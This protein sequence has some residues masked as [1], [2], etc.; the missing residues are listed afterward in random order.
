MIM[1][2]HFRRLFSKNLPIALFCVCLVFL[3]GCRWAYSL[4]A[5]DPRYAHLRICAEKG[6]LNPDSAMKLKKQME[7][8][9]FLEMQQKKHQKGE[10]VSSEETQVSSETTVV[11]SEKTD[12]I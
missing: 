11:S 12:S 4:I 10:P 2:E 9:G 8:R 3:A 7:L 5:N 1:N 6:I